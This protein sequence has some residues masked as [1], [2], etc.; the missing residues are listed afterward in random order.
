ML[1]D[2]TTSST[3]TFFS[4][5]EESL[6]ERNIPSDDDLHNDCVELATCIGAAISVC[7]TCIKREVAYIDRV[8]FCRPCIRPVWCISSSCVGRLKSELAYP[9]LRSEGTI[10]S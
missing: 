10:N 1:H 3:T 2:T 8:N 7:Y 9:S 6:R 4:F 5:G